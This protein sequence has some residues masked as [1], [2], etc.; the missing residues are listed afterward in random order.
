MKHRQK[1]KA[2]DPGWQPWAQDELHLLT[3]KDWKTVEKTGK[4]QGS[5]E[6]AQA[7]LEARKEQP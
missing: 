5:K 7:L 2:E 1:P 6:K 3:E 4:Y